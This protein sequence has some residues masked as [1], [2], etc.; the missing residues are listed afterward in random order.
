MKKNDR[1]FAK[2]AKILAV[3]SLPLMVFSC[4]M[5][6]PE[7][8]LPVV[9]PQTFSETG[10]AGMPE[11]W[12]EAFGDPELNRLVDEA[13]SGNFEISAAWNRLDQA[14]AIARKSG[15]ALWPS[16]DGGAGAARQVLRSSQTGRDYTTDLSLGLSA[17]YEVDLWGGVAA[18]RDA[19]VL[20]AQATAEDVKTARLTVS[21][22]VAEAWFR[23]LEYRMRLA[24]VDKQIATNEKYL[25][26]IERQFRSG[27]AAITDVLQQRQVVEARRGGRELVLATLKT[28]ENELAVLLGRMPGAGFSVGRERPKVPELPATGVP[29]EV[30]KRR[31]DV[32][33]AELRLA[34]ASR[35]AAVAMADRFPQLRL[36]LTAQTSDEDV[37]DLFDNWLANVAADLT[38][39]LFDAGLRLAEIDRTQAVYLEQLNRYAQTVLEAVLEVED[40]LETERRQAAYA[41]SL[42]R[43]LELSGQAL[44]QTLDR[45]TKGSMT[46]T[47]YLT[48]LLD[49]QSLELDLVAARR[50]VLSARVSLYRALAGDAEVE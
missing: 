27:Q 21:A 29:V 46:F 2:I 7:E 19:A 17:G 42:E 6:G 16:L 35:E 30:L 43:Q 25:E 50:A 23:I 49:Y 18:A 32:R 39:P 33:A 34:S 12:W 3:F 15:A 14:R 37:R 26:I 10:E 44:E 38:A 9:V 1:K 20:D 8:P 22:A 11:R 40:A 4:V 28:T 5:P 41:A 31:P 48:A 13:L 24:L 36:G 47:R 45:Y